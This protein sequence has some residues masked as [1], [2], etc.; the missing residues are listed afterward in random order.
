MTLQP[1]HVS[2]GGLSRHSS[3]YMGFLLRGDTDIFDAGR[4]EDLP[5][6]ASAFCC[7]TR[8][9]RR[10]DSN[11]ER[12]NGRYT[13]RACLHRPSFKTLPWNVSL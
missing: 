2:R 10:L 1:L 13:P 4:R 7:N 6:A 9:Y 3:L 5:K 8:N 11:P 12:L